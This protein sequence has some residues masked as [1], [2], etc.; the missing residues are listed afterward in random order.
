MKNNTKG[1]RENLFL[2]ALFTLIKIYSRNPAVIFQDWSSYNL[3]FD[4]IRFLSFVTPQYPHYP[5]VC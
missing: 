1:E 4:R 2:N 5:R 3:T